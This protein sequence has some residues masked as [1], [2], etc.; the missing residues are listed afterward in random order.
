MNVWRLQL[1]PSPEMGINHQ[2]VLDFCEKNGIIGVGWNQITCRTDSYDDLREAIQ[3]SCYDNKRGA[4]RAINAMRQMQP[5][6]L[7]WTRQGGFGSDYYLCRVGKTLWKDRVITPEHIRY[8]ISNY[9]SAEWA[10]IGT[11]DVVPG[12]VVASFRARGSAQR[13]YEVEDISKYIWNQHCKNE[14]EKYQENTLDQ[15]QFWNLIGSEDLECLVLLYLQRKGY[16]LYSST[17]KRDTKE[18]EAV[19]VA[20]DGSHRAFPQVKQNTKL[21]PKDYTGKLEPNDLTYLFSSSE[22]YG[23]PHPQAVC[24]SRQEIEDFIKAD[25][26]ILPQTIKNWL[27]MIVR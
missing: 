23:M 15:S 9:V 20:S 24:I 11:E 4:L 6:D 18:F 22:E 8:D 25:Y 27:A 1:K 12:K 7:I 21:D 5:G 14:S 2:D 17:V 16:L 19:M 10:R 26:N 3:T 13:I